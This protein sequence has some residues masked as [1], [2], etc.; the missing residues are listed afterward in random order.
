MQ[1][2]AL[3]NLQLHGAERA[4][5]Y[6]EELLTSARA[7][8]DAHLE[9]RAL[10]TLAVFASDEGRHRV[11]LRML[12]D[13]YRIDHDLG[14][15]TELMA[16]DEASTRLVELRHDQWG[17]F[18]LAAAALALA[19]VASVLHPAFALPLFLGAV[20]VGALGM[21]ALWRRWE[22]LERLAGEPHSYVIP[23]VIA[24][25]RRETT[26]ERRHNLAARLRRLLTEPGLASD[27]RT[28]SISDD[29]E[30]LASELDDDTLALD[31]A[32]AVA[33]A[34]LLGDPAKSPLLNPSLPPDS[35]RSRISLIRSGFT[36]V[37]G[38]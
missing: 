21:R 17:D 33:C 23:D 25:A 24:Y 1:S 29:L 8:G 2:L 15:P 36:P 6:Y 9:G 20:V 5:P 12:G 28:R 13:A 22:L 31:P 19:L 10:A 30:A 38:R 4:T 27:S 32:S 35:L 16:L 18:G 37:T 11:A 14:D 34:R 26:M 3:C 7:A